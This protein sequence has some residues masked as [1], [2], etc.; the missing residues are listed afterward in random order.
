[1]SCWN[2]QIDIKK[3]QNKVSLFISLFMLTLLFS[4][5][6]SLK[7]DIGPKPSVQ[8]TF[9]GLG[10]QSVYATLLSE[11]P[12]TGPFSTY[13]KNG[14]KRFDNPGFAGGEEIWTAFH[15]YKDADGYYF[16]QRSFSVSDTENLNW[17]YYPPKKFK[18]LLYY[19]ES[20]TYQTS[21]IEKAYA[22]DSYFTVNGKE[23]E[24]ENLLILK[25]TYFYEGELLFL[26]A[27]IFF[28][29]LIEVFIALLF[30][31]RGKKLLLFLLGVN[32]VTQVFLNLSLNLL[33]NSFFR[34]ILEILFLL[35][36]V[37]VFFIELKLY[38]KFLPRVTEKEISKNKILVY[39]IVANAGS[40]LVGFYIARFLPGIF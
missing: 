29:I 9:K 4:P 6:K 30:G 16:L 35:L 1:M 27:R 22:F 8:I 19:P 15:D 10:E 2:K 14:E 37:C 36:E 11:T 12:S 3:T 17:N 28:T 33:Y 24:G 23:M 13:E 7:A 38:Q 32:V 18:L 34:M 25:K 20:K 31:F 39:S 26:F 5:L 21:Y 40:F